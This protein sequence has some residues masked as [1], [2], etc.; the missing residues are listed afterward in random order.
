M[1]AFLQRRG[2]NLLAQHSTLHDTNVLGAQLRTHLQPD[3]GR[4]RAASHA[5]E[6]HL[7]SADFNQATP[8]PAKRY[9]TAPSASSG[10]SIAPNRPEHPATAVPDIIQPIDPSQQ[11]PQS[12]T[13]APRRTPQ[14]QRAADATA[15]KHSWESCNLQ[16]LPR[17]HKKQQQQQQQPKG[18]SSQARL[19]ETSP[20]AIIAAANESSSK[21]HRR[22]GDDPARAF[23]RA[24][25]PSGL[26][27]LPLDASVDAPPAPPPVAPENPEALLR[28]SAECN[29]S[30]LAVAYQL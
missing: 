30:M 29:C 20:S 11:K 16:D 21:L 25:I 19:Q 15:E 9:S 28:V 24:G 7:P 26:W 1:R 3:V 18:R 13:S 8:L 17:A 27:V 5:A 23:M 14:P 22:R 4:T 2:H 6:Q 10:Y 12:S